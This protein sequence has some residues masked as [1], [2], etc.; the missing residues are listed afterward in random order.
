MFAAI[1]QAPLV[2]EFGLHSVRICISGG[3]PLPIEVQEAFEKLTLGSLLEGYGLS[4][5]SPVTHASPVQGNRK[6]GSIGLPLPNT[7]AKIIDFVTGEDLPPGYIGELVI[8]GPQVMQGY[9]LPDGSLDNSLVLDDGWLDTGDVALQDRDGYF[10]II[11]RFSEIIHRAGGEVVYPRD[12]EEVIYE[13][14]K[15]LE[16]AVLGQGERDELLGQ[17][18]V[19]F[20]VPRP[21]TTLTAEE[22]LALC[23]KRLEDTAVPDQIIFRPSLPKSFIGKT[24]RRVLAAELEGEGSAVYNAS[25]RAEALS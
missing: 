23:H 16:V 5:A 15:V 14:N 24:L 17:R 1:N 13:N 4:E 18:I 12:V 11:N 2:R 19:A 8:Q 6:E 9:W 21:R 3:S 25:L 22:I 7:N 20:V 10:R